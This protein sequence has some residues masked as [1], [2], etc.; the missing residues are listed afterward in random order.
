[1][2]WWLDLWYWLI[3]EWFLPSTRNCSRLIEIFIIELS[4]C[5]VHLLKLGKT[6]APNKSVRN[7]WLSDGSILTATIKH[8]ENS[9]MLIS[10]DDGLYP[11]LISP[12][13]TLSNS[14]SIQFFC[15]IGHFRV[16]TCTQCIICQEHVSEC[17]LAV[18]WDKGFVQVPANKDCQ[19]DFIKEMYGESTAQMHTPLP[20]QQHACTEPMAA[21][22]MP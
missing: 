21:M 2:F 1:M 7:S 8:N 3:I 11:L 6:T 10:L 12:F 18:C 13:G 14:I 5:H 4:E 20:E 19:P 17:W 22:R 16:S 15:Q 9:L